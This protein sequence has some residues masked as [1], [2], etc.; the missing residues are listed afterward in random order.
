MGIFL[1]SWCRPPPLI[2]NSG[3]PIHCQWVTAIPSRRHPTL[4]TDLAKRLA[5]QLGIPFLPSWNRRARARTENDAEQ[6]HA[7]TQRD[8]YAGDQG[9]I[10]AGPVL[11][12]DDMIDSG[13]TLTMA[14]Y[15]LRAHGS[16]WSIPLHSPRH[17]EG[18]QH[19]DLARLTGVLLL[20]SHLG[21]PNDPIGAADA[22]RVESTGT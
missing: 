14:G 19:D 11:L 5:N 6:Q 10:P 12:V 1:T 17:P 7:S 16:G 4:V 18:I 20:C 8:R 2:R 9:G 21:L 3:S 15:L 13:W 22:A